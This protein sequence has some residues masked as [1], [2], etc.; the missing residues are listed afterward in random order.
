MIQAGDSGTRLAIRLLQ[1]AAE[2]GE[3][4][5]WDVDVIAVVDGFLDQL[6]QKLELPR[7]IADIKPGKDSNV[8][9]WRDGARKDLAVEIGKQPVTQKVAGNDDA[10]SGG[11][12]DKVGLAVQPLTPDIARELGMPETAKG[13]VVAG[14]KPG[15]PAAEKGLRRGDV[16]TKAGGKELTSP[17]DLTESLNQARKDGR[18]SVLA[19]VKRNGG[20]RFIAIPV[21]AA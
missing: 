14:V 11:I 8:T 16:L 18:K 6:R 1:D 2:R 15:S 7:L 12:E 10:G 20:Q 5:P 19:L 3:I 9:V 21:G 4:E 17:R 13:V